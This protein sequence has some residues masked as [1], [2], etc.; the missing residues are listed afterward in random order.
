MQHLLVPLSSQLATLYGS[1]V[2]NDSLRPL[3][4]FWNTVSSDRY[5]AQIGNSSPPCIQSTDSNHDTSAFAG[6]D[7]SKH[8]M[9]PA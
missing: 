3:A 1:N 8:T 2:C 5:A 7:D 9:W 4:G 6:T